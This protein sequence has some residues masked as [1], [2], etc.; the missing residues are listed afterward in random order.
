MT[1]AFLVLYHLFQIYSL[2]FLA[3]V[4]ENILHTE[5]PLKT[6]EATYHHTS[7]TGFTLNCAS[8]HLQHC[9]GYLML[10]K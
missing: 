7:Q 2:V 3:T 5:R 8:Y 9:Q 10:H 4:H 1:F 6:N